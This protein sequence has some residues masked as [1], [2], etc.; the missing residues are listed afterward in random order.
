[1]LF[2]IEQLFLDVNPNL[3]QT[4]TI[5]LNLPI[6]M[7]ERLQEFKKLIM[8]DSIASLQ[9]QHVRNA[10]KLSVTDELAYYLGQKNM[11]ESKSMKFV[12]VIIE[13]SA[14]SMEKISSHSI[15][16]IIKSWLQHAG[17]HIN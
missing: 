9:Y 11:I 17:D 5:N 16:T 13:Q 12:D 15:Q 14:L 3:L 7:H 6:A 1:M 8:E 2:T 4:N 10:L